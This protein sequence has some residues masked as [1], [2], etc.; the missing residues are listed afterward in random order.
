VLDA[1]RTEQLSLIT[2]LERLLGIEVEVEVEVAE[3]RRHTGRLRFACLPSPHTLT[4]LDLTS[5]RR[6]ARC[7]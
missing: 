7:R 4:D 6:P 1:A 2:T 3:A 5:A